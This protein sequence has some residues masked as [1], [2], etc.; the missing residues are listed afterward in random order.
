MSIRKVTNNELCADL[1]GCVGIEKI[2]KSG[3]KQELLTGPSHHSRLSVSQTQLEILHLARV[4]IQFLAYQSHEGR[5][6]F[7]RLSISWMEEKCV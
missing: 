2:I 6:M 3:R 1:R 5:G 4:Y 7:R